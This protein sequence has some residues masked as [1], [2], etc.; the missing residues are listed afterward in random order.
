GRAVRP[1][2]QDPVLLDPR[3]VGPGGRLLTGAHASRSA[4]A[5]GDRPMQRMEAPGAEQA[6]TSRLAP[7]ATDLQRTILTAT[8]VAAVVRFLRLG[9]Q[10]LWIDEQF[11]LAAAGLPG[12]LDWRDLLQNIHGPLHAL[13]VAL[14][15]AI[16]GPSEW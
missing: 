6:P 12:R 7:A 16:G 15:A 2:P 9:H 11:T 14:A 13:A 5:P 8:L 3:R 1:R 4:H 10:S